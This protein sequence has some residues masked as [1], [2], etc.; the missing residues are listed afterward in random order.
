MYDMQ[1]MRLFLLGIIFLISPPVIA[2][3]KIEIKKEDV[4]DDLFKTLA[5]V[6][7]GTLKYAQAQEKVIG[8]L[9]TTYPL[10]LLSSNDSDWLV[11]MM[12]AYSN[13]CP[14]ITIKR[15]IRRTLNRWATY[16]VQAGI[17]MWNRYSSRT[18]L[19][20]H[21]GLSRYRYIKKRKK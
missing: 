8:T 14:D 4:F 9:Q 1:I 21:R 5:N 10:V 11:G 18:S 15:E 19:L 2:V 17:R 13:Y 12:K 6:E 16:R 7:P 20:M 3:E